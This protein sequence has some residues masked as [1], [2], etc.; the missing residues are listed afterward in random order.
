M[1]WTVLGEHLFIVCAA[2]IASIILGLFLGIVA[3]LCH[4]CV[5]AFSGWWMCFR[6]FLHWHFWV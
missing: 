3:Y 1:S 6:P 5:R 4:L 2:S